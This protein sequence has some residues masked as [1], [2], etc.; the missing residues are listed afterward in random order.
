MG[1]ESVSEESETTTAEAPYMV[2]I[3]GFRVN[4]SSLAAA[5]LALV[6]VW[7]GERDKPKE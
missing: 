2:D 4:L 6:V 5:T 7:A 3:E 1:E